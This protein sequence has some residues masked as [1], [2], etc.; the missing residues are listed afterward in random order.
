MSELESV[1]V[2]F[3]AAMARLSLLT[4]VV[5]RDLFLG[6]NPAKPGRGEWFDQSLELITGGR[7]IAQH[8]TTTYIQLIS[9]LDSGAAPRAAD[10]DLVTLSDLREEFFTN[11]SHII[12][13][14][15][16]LEGLSSR[17]REVA[18]RLNSL[19]QD[20]VNLIPDG[21]AIEALTQWLDSRGGDKSIRWFG[22]DWMVEGDG[23][24]Q[25]AGSLAGTFLNQASVT[26]LDRKLR[27]LGDDA[28]PGAVGDVIEQHSWRVATVIDKG[29][30]DGSRE[31][32]IKSL[33]N[34]RREKWVARGVRPGCCAFCA[35]LASRGFVYWSENS[36]MRNAI[37]EQY[38]PNCH[39]YPIVRWSSKVPPNVNQ[40]WSKAW[41]AHA[42]GTGAERRRSFA[43]WLYQERKQ[44]KQK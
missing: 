43:K 5:A 29:V 10:S 30:Q 15:F 38:H 7:E 1:E 2:L 42:T 3:R 14:D 28:T 8:F 37:G 40:Q 4:G 33:S 16:P 12:D 13:V 22:M 23:A 32:L 11:M 17:G 9:A 31:Y 19:P 36:A 6:S 27:A 24:R 25:A 41:D 39:C 26:D 18:R 20:R 44:N 35:M 34:D 21:E